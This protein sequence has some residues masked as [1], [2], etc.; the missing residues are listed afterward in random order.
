MTTCQ[1]CHTE[2]S[3][4]WFEH[5]TVEYNG[6]SKIGKVIKRLMECEECNEINK[7]NILG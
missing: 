7:G 2:I 5:S 4:K 3:G 1:T 6:N